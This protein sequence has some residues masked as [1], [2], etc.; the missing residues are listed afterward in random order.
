LEEEELKL[1]LLKEVEP[2]SQEE[3]RKVEIMLEREAEEII[4]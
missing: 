2:K 4:L 1:E 3:A